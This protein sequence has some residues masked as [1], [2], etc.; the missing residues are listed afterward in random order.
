MWF[1]WRG[2][3]PKQDKHTSTSVSHGARIQNN[4]NTKYLPKQGEDMRCLEMKPKTFPLLCPLTVTVYVA[5][6]C[7][8]GLL[9][10]DASRYHE[11][12]RRYPRGDRNTVTNASSRIGITTENTGRAS[13]FPRYAIF[14]GQ[15]KPLCN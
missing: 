11:K 2:K 9:R 10:L 14:G 12:L 5:L 15:N 4:R 8:P 6:V 1:L 13:P 3:P 7:L